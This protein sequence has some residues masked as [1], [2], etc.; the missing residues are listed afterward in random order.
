SRR[1]APTTAMERGR[2]V[3]SRLRTVIERSLL[4]ASRRAREGQSATTT[5]EES[6]PVRA[7]PVKW[8]VAAQASVRDEDRHWCF[9]KHQ[10]RCAAQ[11]PFANARMPVAAHDDKIGADLPGLVEQRR[12]GLIPAGELADLCRYAVPAEITA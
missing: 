8:Q 4:K 10:A 2:N 11:D 6:G 7:E 3:G 1:D 12:A 9:G 5:Q